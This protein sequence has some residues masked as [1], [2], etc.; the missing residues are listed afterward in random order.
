[1]PPFAN[2]SLLM[3]HAARG[4]PVPEP[5]T[6]RHHTNVPSTWLEPRY[7]VAGPRAATEP[8]R[9]WQ[10]SRATVQIHCLARSRRP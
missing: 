7:V 2:P 4:A 9:P 8:S 1:M 6:H 10:G 3:P 5:A